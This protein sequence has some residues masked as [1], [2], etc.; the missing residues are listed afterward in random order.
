M[1]DRVKTSSPFSSP[2]TFRSSLIE[3]FLNLGKPV[4]AAV[5]GYCLGGRDLRSCMPAP[6]LLP[7]RGPDSPSRKSIWASTLWLAPL[8]SCLCWWAGKKPWRSSCWGDVRCRPGLTA[9]DYRRGGT[10]LNFDGTGERGRDPVSRQAPSG[11]EIH[12]GLRLAGRLP[13]PGLRPGF[14][15]Q[16][17]HHLLHEPG[18]HPGFG[19]ISFET[20]AA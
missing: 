8:S 9:G 1:L 18:C 12:Y 2:L 5:N 20:A 3:P 13:D 16:M 15:G 19:G 17:L 14:R 4:I 10:G 7:Q 11:S 6:S